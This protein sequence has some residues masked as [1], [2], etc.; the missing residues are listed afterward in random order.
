MNDQFDLR[1]FVDAQA[2]V[3]EAALA[4]LRAGRKQ[5]HWM[6][7]VFPQFRGLGESQMA[8]KFAIQSLDE[9]VSYLQHPLLGPRLKEVTRAVNEIQ[10][11]SIETIFGYPDYLKFRSSM[12]LFSKA[13][14]DEPLFAQALAKYFGGAADERTLALL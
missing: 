9:A 8:Q 6:W 14:P 4:E 2:P 12:T 7:Y 1:R 13:A 3:F 10:G 11:R 5:S